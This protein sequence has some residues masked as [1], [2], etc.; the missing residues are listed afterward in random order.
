MASFG[1]ATVHEVASEPAPEPA[2]AGELPTATSAAGADYVPSTPLEARIAEVI[3]SVTEKREQKPK[4]VKIQLQFPK[5]AAVF[6]TVKATFTEID[7]DKSGTIE[8][9]EIKGALAKVR[10]RAP[11]P[12]Y[13]YHRPADRARAHTL[14]PPPPSPAVPSQS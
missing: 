3:K 12:A 1:E 11:S 10:S 13:A 4:F 2:P 9:G 8:L 6:E 7:A 5:V 14:P